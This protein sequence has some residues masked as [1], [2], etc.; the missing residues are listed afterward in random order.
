MLTIAALVAVITAQMPFEQLVPRDSVATLRSAKRA[1]ADFETRR[2]SLLPEVATSGG[3]CDAIIGRF[4]YWVDDEAEHPQEPA[5][6]GKLRENLLSRLSA[7]ATASPGDRW[8]A[9]QRVR[10]LVEGGRFGDALAAARECRAGESW[11]AALA[12]LALHA[13]GETRAA[14][15]AVTVSLGAMPEAE[16]CAAIDIEP[17]LD[18][19]FR[20]RFHKATC[21]ERDSLATRWWWLAQ[22]LYLTDGNPLRAELFARRTL[23]RLAAESR[24]PYAM[25]P[26]K[27]LEA[28]VLRYGWPVA[29][30]KPPARIGMTLGSE[31]AVG[32]DA[33]PT[34]AFGP[35]AR[36]L[37]DVSSVGDD[38]YHLTDPRAPARFTPTA[39][40]A[41]GLVRR[42]VST[43]RRGD[44][45]L[46]VAAFDA[47]GDTALANVRDPVP[48]LVLLRDE[49]TA[50]VIVKGVAGK[51][52]VLT[53]LS[54]WRPA[55]VAVEMLDS[56]SKR[57]AR[58]RD[59]LS[60]RDTVRYR[61]D[62]SD[63]LLFRAADSSSSFSL[64]GVAASALASDRIV[65]GTRLGLF[66]EMYGLVANERVTAT[67]GLLPNGSGLLR[68]L[69]ERAR[70]A[71]PRSPVHLQWSD[72]PEVLGSV[73][74]RALV[75]ELVDI[76]PG[77]YTVE[78]TVTVDG[79]PAMRA[80]SAV[81]IVSP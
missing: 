75:L 33:K 13:M 40:T 74:G 24:S 63:L 57:S 39:V 6:I 34:L 77:R 11:C 21:A 28:M 51:R 16:R 79:Q 38:S 61:V 23:A 26:G 71:E 50:P 10:Y 43:F 69:A 47:E 22:P 14:D 65:S 53:A 62:L 29:W 45:T 66:W 48:A 44:S 46:V 60:S 8:I 73:G 59:G 76:P 17:L 58:A 78:L 37:E 30:G 12:A 7:Y 70:L 2:H 80:A 27:D 36:A 68:R 9:G 41:I 42:H 3:R 4:C 15:S 72:A 1:Q 55:L 5:R 32:F 20:D 18:G 64:D 25:S 54:P 19:P 56:A 35:S 31:G 67:V 52:G 81:E 49:H